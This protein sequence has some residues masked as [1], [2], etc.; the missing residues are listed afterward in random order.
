M[1]IA[2]KTK[3]KGEME[4]KTKSNVWQAKEITFANDLY[5]NYEIF[6]SNKIIVCY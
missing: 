2:I 6:S 5:F 1:Q 4:I 3:R